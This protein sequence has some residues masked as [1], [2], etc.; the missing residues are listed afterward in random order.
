M[1]NT[2]QTEVAC[3]INSVS[4]NDEMHGQWTSYRPDCVVMSM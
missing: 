1:H 2:W 3:L 4:Y